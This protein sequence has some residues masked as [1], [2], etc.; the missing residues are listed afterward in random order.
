MAPTADGGTALFRFRGVSHAVDK[1][2]FRGNPNA[3][4]NQTKPSAA[5]MTGPAR[6]IHHPVITLHGPVE[7]LYRFVE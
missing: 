5:A 4:K 6:S 3:R 7:F 2:V 1:I